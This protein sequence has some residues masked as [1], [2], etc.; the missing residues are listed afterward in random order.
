MIIHIV[1]IRCVCKEGFKLG[2]D[3][4]T[5]EPAED[6][7][8]KADE[9]SARGEIIAEPAYRP[10]PEMRYNIYKKK[11]LFGNLLITFSVL[12]SIILYICYIVLDLDPLPSDLWCNCFQS[13]LLFIIYFTFCGI[14]IQNIIII[15]IIPSL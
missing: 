15:N 5:C 14:F 10:K 11:P 12:S 3:N 6:G 9:V 7:D 8:N 2:N 4:I 13:S 1:S